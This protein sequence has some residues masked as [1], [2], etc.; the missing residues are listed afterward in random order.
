MDFSP[1]HQFLRGSASLRETCFS[2][3]WASPTVT[4]IPNEKPPGGDDPPPGGS[5]SD[6]MDQVGRLPQK[7]YDPVPEYE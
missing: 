3:S 7:L 6:P 2:R 4:V 1:V 5:R